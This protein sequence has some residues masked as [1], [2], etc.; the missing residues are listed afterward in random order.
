MLVE[1]VEDCVVKVHRSTNHRPQKSCNV[2]LKSSVRANDVGRQVAIVVT[3]AVSKM[4][5]NFFERILC[6]YIV[7]IQT[8]FLLRSWTSLCVSDDDEKL[9]VDSHRPFQNRAM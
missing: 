7:C 6:I 3:N 1:R 8:L 4:F 9:H 5:A 2:P